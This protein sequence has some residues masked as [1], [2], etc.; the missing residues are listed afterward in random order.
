[1]RKMH[2]TP[3]KGGREVRYESG[4]VGRENWEVCRESWEV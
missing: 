3:S 1:M 4:E 2:C